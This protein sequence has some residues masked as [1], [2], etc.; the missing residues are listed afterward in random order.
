MPPKKGNIWKKSEKENPW[1]EDETDT[2]TT[3][4]ANEPIEVDDDVSH[5]ASE[6]KEQGKFQSR[7][8]SLYTWLTYDKD[9]NKMYCSKC[10]SIGANNTMIAGCD[11]FKTSPLTIG[12][13]LVQITRFIASRIAQNCWKS[14]SGRGAPISRPNGPLSSKARV[15]SATSE[16]KMLTNAK[17]VN[18]ILN[19]QI[20]SFYF[21]IFFS[22]RGNLTIRGKGSSL[23]HTT[24]FLLFFIS[25]DAE[26]WFKWLY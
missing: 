25:T 16:T 3:T 13:Q 17:R 22:K 4:E 20:P 19:T 11:N 5:Q 2:G 18:T 24:I 21:Q 10:I 23:L 14:F 6:N 15:I 7:W 12:M 26:T 1:S 8:A 9:K